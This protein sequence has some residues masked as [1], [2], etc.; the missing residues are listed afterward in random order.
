MFVFSW[1]F[2]R[3]GGH[4]VRVLR[5][6]DDRLLHH[7]HRLDR[8]SVRR[9][10]LPHDNHQEALAKVCFGLFYVGTFVSITF[11]TLC[12]VQAPKYIFVIL[13]VPSR[14]FGENRL[15]LTTKLNFS[16]FCWLPKSYCVTKENSCRSVTQQFSVEFVV[17]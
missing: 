12:L 3:N 14:F 6:H 5:G 7:P 15:N 4:H 13:P 1:M 17:E 16:K 11:L 8:R 10:L 2:F 9:H